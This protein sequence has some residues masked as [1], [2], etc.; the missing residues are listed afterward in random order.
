[1]ECDAVGTERTLWLTTWTLNLSK[2]G[3]IS[4]KVVR[5]HLSL[6]SL[7]ETQGK[8]EL[9][10]I[11]EALRFI[12]IVWKAL[13]IWDYPVI[14]ITYI[15]WTGRKHNLY[16]NGTISIR[17]CISYSNA[18]KT[19]P[20]RIAVKTISVNTQKQKRRTT[21]VCLLTG[22]TMRRSWKN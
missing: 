3:Q 22:F 8:V 14:T 1:M 10:Q 4:A 20:Q 21:R 5:I 7:E 11:S 17:R 16:Y 6:V 18:A 12:R 2:R 13:K 15:E 9:V 19:V